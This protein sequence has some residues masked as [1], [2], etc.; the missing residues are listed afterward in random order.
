MKKVLLCLLILL[1]LKVFSLSTS[2]EAAILMDMDNKRILYENNIHKVKSVA[3][4]SKIMTAVIALESGKINDIV[5]VDDEVLKA[6]GSAI[7]IQRGE[8]IKLIDLIY[9]LMLRSGNDAA[10]VISK[11][12]AGDVSSFV[13]KMNEKAKQIGMKK[14]NFNNPSGLDN[15][16]GNYSTAYDMALLTS[17]AMQNKLYKKI[18]KTKK[19]TVKTNKNFYS[20]LNKNKILS[21]YKYSTGGKTG[22]TEIARRTLVT[23]AS[24]K[25]LNLVAVTLNDGNDFSDHISLFKDAFTTYKNI[26]ILKSGSINVIGDK[27]YKGKELYLKN[28]FNY[29]LQKNELKSLYLKIELEKKRIINFNKPVGKV[30]V[31]LGDKVIYKDN[32]YLKEKKRKKWFWWFYGK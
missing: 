8:K 7:Y 2:A 12:V 22:F 32:I 3:S 5:T 19:H 30:F 18:V 9:G 13:F 27:Y 23:T 16:K 20:W 10:L 25:G 15:D 14:T 24:Y 28:N 29:P 17:Y 4:I 6:Y 11:F 31:M 21:L 26:S 1:P